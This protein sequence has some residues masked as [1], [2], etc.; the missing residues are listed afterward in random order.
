MKTIK[1]LRESFTLHP[2][3]IGTNLKYF[4]NLNIDWDVFLPSIGKNLQR[5]FVWTLEQK[6]ELIW[7]VFIGR[8][9]PHLAIVNTSSDV[10]QIIDGKQRLS[11]LIDFVNDKFALEIDGAEM[12]YSQ[13]PVDYQKALDNLY[14]RYY[15]LCE[16]F[17]EVISDEDKIKWFQ[18]INFAGTP[19]DMEHMLT[20]GDKFLV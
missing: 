10:Y 7:S 17:D 20:L 2:E 16:N 9:I 13:L 6:R 1:E 8:H 14:F 5:G 19:Q 12:L 15:R 4:K 18:F 3:E 11:T